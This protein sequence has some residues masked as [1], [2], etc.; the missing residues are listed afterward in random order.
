MKKVYLFLIVNF[1]IM[2]GVLYQFN[3]KHKDGYHPVEVLSQNNEI[4][5]KPLTNATV[6][7][8][9]Q[10]VISP[11]IDNLA[12]NASTGVYVSSCSIYGPITKENKIFIDSYLKQNNLSKDVVNV[13]DLNKYNVYWNLGEDRNLATKIFDKEKTSKVFVNNDLKLIKNKYGWVVSLPSIYADL[14]GIKKTVAD[15]NVST[16][17]IGGT[18]IYEK[19]GNATFYKFNAGGLTKQQESGLGVLEKSVGF[20]KTDCSN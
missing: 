3:L 14:I 5:D 11:V 4:I 13:I 15:L 12:K 17:K 7:V 8:A 6:G 1:F 19:I 20:S 9:T 18:W 2:M 10:S 16:N